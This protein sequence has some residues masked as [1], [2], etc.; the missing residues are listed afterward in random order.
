MKNKFFIFSILIHLISFEGLTKVYAELRAIDRTTG[1]TYKVKAPLNEEVNF[2]NL[3]I[4]VK[5]CYKNPIDKK[6]ENYAYIKIKDGLQD[7]VIFT[8]WMFSSSPSLSGLEHP[9]NDIWLLD[10]I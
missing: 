8:G 6:I 4:T 9:I 5:Y 2:S 1:R 7:K 10:C 3:L